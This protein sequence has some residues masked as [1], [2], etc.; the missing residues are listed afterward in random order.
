MPNPCPKC[1]QPTKLNAKFCGKCGQALSA[2]AVTGPASPPL[3]P[4]AAVTPPAPPKRSSRMLRL[5]AVGVLIYGLGAFGVVKLGQAMAATKPAVRAVVPVALALSPREAGQRGLNWL[6]TEATAWQAQQRCYGCHV[7]SFAIMGAAVAQG[8]DYT[9]NLAQTRQLADYLVA[10]QG[11]DGYIGAGQWSNPGLIVQTVLAG[12]GFS[13]YDEM[14]GTEYAE[15]L[16]RLAD[17]LVD[18]QTD[19]GYWPLDHSEA[20]VDQGEAMTTGAALNALAAAQ[21]HN[22]NTAYTH[23]IQQG[24]AWL[25]TMTPQTTQDLVF[26]VIGLKASG[27]AND[28]PD[29]TRLLAAL[30]AQRNGDGGWGETTGLSSNGYATGQVLY[31][32]QL[33]G[34]DLAD[35]SFTQGVLWLL[36]HQRPDGSWPQVNSQQ[37][38]SG[39]SSQ[40]ATTM[41]AVIGLGEIFD[42]ATEAAFISLIHPT[43]DGAALPS[44]GALSAFVTLPVLLFFPLWWKRQGHHWSAGRQK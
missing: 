2:P 3:T 16:V 37:Q 17:W 1:G 24:A 44:A 43:A 13:R 39:R 9:V 7:Q 22:A 18:Q 11:N 8:S 26:A 27:A 15:T 10:L 31:A 36:N 34:V 29:V 4:P 33:A 35:D 25:R 19:A 12:I 23:A 14:V 32:Y 28:D 21:R 5:L 41:W 42:K 38:N 6:L 20:P 30:K 40:Y